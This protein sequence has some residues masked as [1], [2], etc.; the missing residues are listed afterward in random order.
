MEHGVVFDVIWVEERTA[1]LS[2]S[3][4][5]GYYSGVAEIVVSP[6][7][8]TKAALFLHHFPRG[9]ND[10][11]HLRFG[12]FNPNTPEGSVI[13]SFH[14]MNSSGRP[15]VDVQLKGAGCTAFG[16][17]ESVAL[18]IPIE[19]AA[20]DAFAEQLSEVLVIGHQAVLRMS[21]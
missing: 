20:V 21:T 3:C 15:V 6:E 13:L 2:V 18:R 7:E 19:P 14:S 16:E 1:E 12:S 4:S 17:P 11:R 10:R 9:R 8:L 5:N